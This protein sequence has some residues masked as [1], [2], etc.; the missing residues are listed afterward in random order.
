M[1]DTAAPKRSSLCSYAVEREE[2]RGERVRVACVFGS[3][4]NA[5]NIAVLTRRALISPTNLLLT[6]LA[7]ADLVTMLFYVPS[8]TS[9]CDLDLDRSKTKTRRRPG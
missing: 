6:A 9:T 3:T 1:V 5:M 4:S 2:R 8:T 7:V